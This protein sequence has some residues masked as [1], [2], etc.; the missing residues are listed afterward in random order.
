MVQIG[1]AHSPRLDVA[2]G[3]ID[4]LKVCHRAQSGCLRASSLATLSLHEGWQDLFFDPLVMELDD[5]IWRGLG[6][7]DKEAAGSELRDLIGAICSS[8]ETIDR[9]PDGTQGKSICDLFRV[10]L[11]RLFKDRIHLFNVREKSVLA[12]L[13]YLASR[14][15]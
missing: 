7:A 5:L 13:H 11:I 6:E 10:E 4:A 14:R 3:G 12:T 15:A 8:Y 2:E 9:V 1:R